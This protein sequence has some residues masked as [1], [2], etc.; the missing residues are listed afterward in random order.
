[1]AEQVTYF[2]ADKGA[3]RL[4]MLDLAAG[5]RTL[6]LAWLLA[7]R[8]MTNRFRGA[9]LG[10][11]WLTITTSATALG[12]SIVYSQVF[13][14]SFREYLPYVATGT[15][16]WVLIS[17]F[18]TE[19]AGVFVSGANYYLQIPMAISTMAYRLVLRQG[20]QTAY[21]ALALIAFY[22]VVAL[23]VAPRTALVVPGLAL[24]FYIGFWI[25]IIG[26]CVNA[27]FRDLGQF[28]VAAMTMAFFVTPVFWRVESLGERAYL[29][30]F[31]P[32]H[33]MMGIVR[34]PLIGASDLG[35]HFAVCGGLAVALTIVGLVTY[36]TCHRRLPYWCA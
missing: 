9:T 2:D 33:H 20:V 14:I 35:L 32:L 30:N 1:M 8:D 7:W 12:L 6:G 34:G 3:G 25:A 24:M 10:M 27:R 16:V 23:D 13:S 29:M 28:L 11:F 36:A 22:V 4:A 31:N 21:R 18:I 19:G 15:V 17:A 26:G 5:A